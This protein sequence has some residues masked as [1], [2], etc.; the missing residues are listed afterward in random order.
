MSGKRWLGLVGAGF[1]ALGTGAMLASGADASSVS[2]IVGF[3]A[4]AFA[5]IAALIGGFSGPR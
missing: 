3:A 4:S 2:G 1:V 5:A